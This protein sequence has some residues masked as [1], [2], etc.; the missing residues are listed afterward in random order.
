[1]DI[2]SQSDS[3]SD[4]INDQFAKLY[5]YDTSDDETFGGV[6]EDIDTSGDDPLNQI[7]LTQ[8]VI[9]R[10]YNPNTTKCYI[11]STCNLNHRWHMHRYD[12][13]R[14]KNSGFMNCKSSLIF[15][16]GF[17]DTKFEILARFWVQHKS[18][19]HS[20][21]RYYINV[22]KEDCVNIANPHSTAEDKR[23]SYIKSCAK[24]RAKPHVLCDR[25]G[26]SVKKINK[27]QQTK[28][29]FNKSLRM[30]STSS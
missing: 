21:E 4:D 10:I 6:A 23:M 28:R 30:N 29:C 1:M 5:F 24:V 20:K 17:E 25:C 16:Y 7:I 3:S 15:D 27:H 14:F 18:E 22:Y 26:M 13:R 12:Y 11:G 2:Q 8:A 9:Y 19:I